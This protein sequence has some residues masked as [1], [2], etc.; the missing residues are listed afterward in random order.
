MNVNQQGFIAS[1]QSLETAKK[2]IVYSSPKME[3]ITV[4]TKEVILSS[5]D[6]WGPEQ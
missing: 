5:T 2:R 4:N 6:P 3:S 1:E